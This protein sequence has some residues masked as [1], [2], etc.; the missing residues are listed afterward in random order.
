MGS[1]PETY[2]D[3]TPGYVASGG[4]TVQRLAKRSNGVF[5]RKLERERLID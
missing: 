1:F 3:P 5:G 2:N 4:C